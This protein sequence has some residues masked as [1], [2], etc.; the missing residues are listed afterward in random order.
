[1]F[2]LDTVI[3]HGAARG[4]DTIAGETA[5]ILGMPVEAYPAD[6][7]KHGRSAGPIRNRKM[8]DTK[9]D[10]VIAFHEDIESS[11]G[12][13]DCVNEALRRGIQVEVITGLDKP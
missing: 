5:R 12:T 13:K 3:V 2:C 9:P 10:L 4:A 8:L 7:N 1:M 6:W 11:K